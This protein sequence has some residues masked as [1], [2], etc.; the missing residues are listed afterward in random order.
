MSISRIS[1]FFSI[2]QI[3]FLSF[4]E[5]KI[6]IEQRLAEKQ[7]ENAKY[8]D[9]S[10]NMQIEFANWKYKYKVMQ[11]KLAELEQ[12]AAKVSAMG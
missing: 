7:E 10:K 1:S 8:L 11:G 2:V 4:K 5:E 12:L 6:E 3:I 9:V